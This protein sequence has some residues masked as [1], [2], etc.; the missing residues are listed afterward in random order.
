MLQ[1]R[2]TRVGTI[3]SD[4]MIKTAVVSIETQQRHRLYGKITKK[5]T[6]VKAHVEIP[7]EVGDLVRIVETRPLSKEKRWIVQEIVQKGKMAAWQPLSSDEQVL[8]VVEEKMTGEVEPVTA[9]PDNIDQ[10]ETSGTQND[11]VN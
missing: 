2:K 7:V 1:N 3:V 5:R 8:G 4:K 6:R 10:E 11:S 9:G